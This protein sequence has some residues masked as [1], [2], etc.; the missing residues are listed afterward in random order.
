MLDTAWISVVR[1]A[2]GETFQNAALLLDGLEERDSAVGGDVASV[3]TG[4]KNV[5]TRSFG[6]DLTGDTL[7]SKPVF[8][9]MPMGFKYRRYLTNAGSLTSGR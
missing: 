3:E 8:V 9:M 1:E 4:D 7:P 6:P 5:A 2:L